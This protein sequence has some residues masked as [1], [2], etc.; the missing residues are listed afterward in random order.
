ML[1]HVL[2]IHSDSYVHIFMFCGLPE[3]LHQVLGGFFFCSLI[4][5]SFFPLPLVLVSS[6]LDCIVY[7]IT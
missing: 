1:G 6:Y 7:S 4:P 2:S 5:L 3:R